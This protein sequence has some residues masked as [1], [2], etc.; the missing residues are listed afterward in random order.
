MASPGG[1][2]WNVIDVTE[3]VTGQAGWPWYEPEPVS[4]EIDSF[5]RIALTTYKPATAGL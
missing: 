2:G 4:E 5:V 3:S 1:R